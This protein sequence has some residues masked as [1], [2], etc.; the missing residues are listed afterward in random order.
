MKPHKYRT[1]ICMA[2]VVVTLVTYFETPQMKIRCIVIRRDERTEDE[3][4]RKIK[5]MN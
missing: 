2:M 3:N 1:I 5:E 4:K